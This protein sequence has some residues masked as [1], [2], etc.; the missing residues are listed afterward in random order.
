MFIVIDALDECPETTRKEL[1]P[2][3]RKLRS[4]ANLLVTTR[5]LM[6]IERELHDAVHLEIHA[7]DTDLETYIRSKTQQD[8]GLAL[9]T[10]ED[11]R[12]QDEIVKTI[13]GNAR[14]M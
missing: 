5:Q 4:V 12:L 2:E 7:L 10:N 13:V 1:I 11:P 6:S 3:I 8:S 14:G 9:Y